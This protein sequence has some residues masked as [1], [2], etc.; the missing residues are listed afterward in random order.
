[1]R[2]YVCVRLGSWGVYYVCAQRLLLGVAGCV[3]IQKTWAPATHSIP[4]PEDRACAFNFW[5]TITVSNKSVE[6]V[7]KS[8]KCLKCLTADRSRRRRCLECVDSLGCGVVLFIGLSS[9]LSLD[10][11]NTSD[12]IAVLCLFLLLF[13]FLSINLWGSQPD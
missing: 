13:F 3:W 5:V 2:A 10:I 12:N 1:M 9:F 11:Q 6:S 4:H 8:P 7:A